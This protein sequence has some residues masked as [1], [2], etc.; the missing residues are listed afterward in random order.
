M[1]TIIVGQFTIAITKDSIFI[2]RENGEGME[3]GEAEAEK[4]IE[5]Y[6]R[7]NF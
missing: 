1:I 2:S 7:E 5:D 4:I 3:I 6:W